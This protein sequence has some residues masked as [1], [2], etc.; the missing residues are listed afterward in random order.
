MIFRAVLGLALVA[1]YLPHETDL[2]LG[3]PGTAASLP[4]TMNMPAVPVSSASASSS[5]GSVCDE[6]ARACAG[7][8]ALLDAFQEGAIRGL[9]EVK[10]EIDASRQARAANSS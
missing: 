8:L 5:Q 9:A 7:G 1:L 4:A 6:H 3:R 10:A 2:G